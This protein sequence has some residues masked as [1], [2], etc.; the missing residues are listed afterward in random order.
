MSMDGLVENCSFIFD[1]SAFHGGRMPQ[2]QDARERLC[3]WKYCMPVLQEQ[4]P[5][6]SMDYQYLA[7]VWIYRNGAPRLIAERKI[8][9]PLHILPCD[10]YPKL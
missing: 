6:M 5:A 9:L 10:D 1:T 7:F 3:T 8:C 4:K 2:A